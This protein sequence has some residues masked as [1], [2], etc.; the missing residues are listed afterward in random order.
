MFKIHQKIEAPRVPDVEKEMN[1]LLDGFGLDGKVQ[2]WRAHRLTAEAAGIRDKAKV[3]KV[4][5]GRYG[6]WGQAFL[7][8]CMGSHGEA[9]LKARCR[10]CPPGITEEYIGAP[11]ISSIEVKEI[12]RTKFGTPVYTDAT[13]YSQ[14][15][16]HRGQ[17]GQAPHRFD[18][19][20]KVESTKMLVI[21]HGQAA[22]GL[23]L[24][25]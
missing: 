11:I 21:G 12:G 23:M 24:T 16:N 15:I 19:R 9:H 6:P 1:H 2:A 18:S 4:I 8:P 10:S 7:V 13:I 14:A 5:A 17:P 3:L 20:S 22:R 25:V